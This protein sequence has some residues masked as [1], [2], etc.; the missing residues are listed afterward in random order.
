[1]E[2][3]FYK[4]LEGFLGQV[5]WY[6]LWTV[7]TFIFFWIAFKNY[8]SKRRIQQTQK[9][10]RTQFLREIKNSVITIVIFAAIDLYIFRDSQQLLSTATFKVYSN[11]HENG[12][13]LY[14]LFTCFILFV[15]E[16]TYF[17]WMH[18]TIH[19][20]KLYK[21][22]H[23]VHHESID[24]T[25]FTS[26]SFHPAEAALEIVPL[27]LIM[28]F[29]YFFPIHISALI[30]WQIGSIAFNVMGHSGYELYPSF[31]NK[32][33]FL[34]WKLPSTHHNMHH[35]KFNGNY[36]LYFIWWDRIM[37]TEFI[38]Y[39]ETYNSVFSKGKT[40]EVVNYHNLKVSS[41]KN[42]C[43]DVYS[44]YFNE[45]PYEFRGYKAGQHITIKIEI[46]KETYYRTFSLS[47]SPTKDNYLRLTIKRNEQGLVTKFL[48]GNLKVNDDLLVGVPKGNFFIE[49]N[50]ANN[51]TL[52]FFAAGSGI[53]PIFSM[54]TTSLNDE[55]NTRIVLFYANRNTANSIFLDELKLLMMKKPNHFKLISYMSDADG[56]VTRNQLSGVVKKERY[57]EYYLCGPSGFMNVAKTTLLDFG[58]SELKINSEGFLTGF[59]AKKEVDITG[60]IVSSVKAIINN[61]E[62]N[63]QVLENELILDAAI[64]QK[65]KIPFSCKSGICG[66]CIATK[67]EGTVLMNEKQI[68]LS[69]QDVDNLKVLL[70]QC[71]PTS[72]NIIIEINS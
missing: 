15:I 11:F 34:K 20:P 21:Y 38:D 7:P 33:W 13:I 62:N 51:R 63:F 6:F 50:P 53:T 19:S 8:F 70:C 44:I 27:G 48:I 3:S 28:I 67:K 2:N 66:T 58:V 42:E 65:I 69:K 68:F 37:R 5:G 45:F 56:R 57:D 60:K 35:A 18:K 54:I 39:E 72:E 14:I 23:K 41:I 40:T 61:Q 24:T 26:Y 32:Y 31:W 59:Q 25:P 22:I 46:G 49:P 71:Y 43:N 17:Y 36:G 12:G 47:S 1:M 29:A 16:D 9:A 55:P 52:L 30:V 4:L 64:R 10:D